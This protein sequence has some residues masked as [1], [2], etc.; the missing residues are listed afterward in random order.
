MEKSKILKT[1]MIGVRGLFDEKANEGHR[2][3]KCSFDADMISEK[4]LL[5][6]RSAFQ[7]AFDE[8]GI[9][10]R[11]NISRGSHKIAKLDVEAEGLTTS[12]MEAID[13]RVRELVPEEI[14]TEAYNG[15]ELRFCRGDARDERHLLSFVPSSYEEQM[16][17]GN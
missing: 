10:G 7:L 9:E 13:A 16:A 2:E 3:F 14:L 6:I 12:Q 1:L 11:C 5:R 4:D 17:L 8:N 15:S